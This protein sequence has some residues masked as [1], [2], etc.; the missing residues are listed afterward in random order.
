MTDTTKPKNEARNTLTPDERFTAFMST[1]W[2]DNTRHTTEVDPVAKY[3]RARRQ[4][5]SAAYRGKRVVIE[6][7]GMKTRANDTDYGFRA[8]SSFVYYTGWGNRTEPDSVLVFEPAGDEHRVTLYFR[9]RADKSSSEFFANPA[10]G[11]FWI[12]PRP[13]LTQVAQ[14]LAIETAALEDF[15]ASDSDVTLADAELLQFVHEQR[16]I[17]DEY[18]VAELRRAIEATH[19]GFNDTVAA[20]PEAKEAVRGERVIETAFHTRARV[21]GN[22][23][24]YDT[25]AAAG[26]HACVLHWVRND[27]PVREGD[28]LLLDAGV[29]VDSLYTAD[30]TRTFPV[31]GK[32]T[33]TQRQVYDA[34]LEAHEAARKAVRPGAKFSEIHQAAMAVIEQKVR[35]WGFWPADAAESVAYHRRYMVHGTGHHLGLDVHDCNQ[36][37]REKYHDGVLEP[38]MVFT[39]EPGMYFHADDVTVPPE[40]RGIGVRIEDNFLVTET[41]SENLSAAIPRT[42]DDVEAWVREAVAS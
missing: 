12:G 28:L 13:S 11:E 26:A 16:L 3:T 4:A 34:V 5:L 18:E 32:F 25:I 17:K 30:I 2:A 38:G 24:G 22:W 40:F 8:D 10:I 41:G 35:E 31:S 9:E 37:R 33:K 36:A 23:V 20:I 15:E 19:R 39:I 14:L 7:G 27:G 1:G 29:E 21:D 42:A 6:A